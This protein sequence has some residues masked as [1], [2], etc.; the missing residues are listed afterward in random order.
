[1]LINYLKTLES[2]QHHGKKIHFG[3]KPRRALSYLQ[4]ITREGKHKARTITRA[5]ILIMANERCLD[6]ANASN[7]RVNISTVE[8]T[9]KK[10]VLRD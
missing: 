3:F 5:K 10:F 6:A 8:R 9:G 1:M 4:S 2:G 7:L